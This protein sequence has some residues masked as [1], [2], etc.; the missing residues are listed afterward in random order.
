MSTS[1][2]DTDTTLAPRGL[3][4]EQ[5]RRFSEE[6]K[7]IIKQRRQIYEEEKRSIEQSAPLLSKRTK[8]MAGVYL[9]GCV[10]I[11]FGIPQS[12]IDFCGTR[13]WKYQPETDIFRSLV[14][15]AAELAR[16]FI[17]VVICG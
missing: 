13:Q 6:E 3:A 12:V 4:D 7:R 10:L 8:I 9:L 16:P 5:W 2:D 1:G 15:A 14:N 11:Y 17:A